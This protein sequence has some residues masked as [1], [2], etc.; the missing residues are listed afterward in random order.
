MIIKKI[1]GKF[2]QL[3]RLLFI[4]FLTL[5]N[6]SIILVEYPKSGGTWL[7]QLVSSYFKIP[8]PR[9]KFPGIKRSLYHGHYLP[10]F[11][12]TKNKKIILLVRDGRRN[13]V[14]ISSSVAL[15]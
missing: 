8:F 6:D 7:G 2:E 11:N 14:V 15:E 5:K 13:G 3:T 4:N 9:N 1:K 12:I 10:K